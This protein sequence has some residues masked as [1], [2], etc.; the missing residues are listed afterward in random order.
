MMKNNTPHINFWT[1]C[2]VNDL[3]MKWEIENGGDGN[4]YPKIEHVD[5]IYSKDTEKNIEVEKMLRKYD[6]T[7]S[8]Y[9]SIID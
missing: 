9:I 4:Y 3:I 5:L 8:E 2:L 7:V 6:I 1:F